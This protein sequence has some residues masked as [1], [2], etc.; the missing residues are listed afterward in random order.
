MFCF[1]T[2]KQEN[3]KPFI[4]HQKR[5][6]LPA[7]PC[8]YIYE[9]YGFYLEYG[10]AGGLPHACDQRQQGQQQQQQQQRHHNT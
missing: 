1:L 7:A 6:N 5:T 4:A 3:I 8:I 10:Q 9:L 2:P